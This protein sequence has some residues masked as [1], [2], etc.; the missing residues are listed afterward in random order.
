MEFDLHSAGILRMLIYPIQFDPEPVKGI[1]RVL[2][3]VVFADHLRLQVPDVIA[4][5]DAGLASNA[6]LSE[7]IPQ[8]HNETVICGFLSAVRVRLESPPP[9]E[10]T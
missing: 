2:K 3:M 7:L 8:G 5:I 10:R 9:A 4:A 6:R 1:D